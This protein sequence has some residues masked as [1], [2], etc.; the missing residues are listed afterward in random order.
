MADDKEKQP[1]SLHPQKEVKTK[2]AAPDYKKA[3]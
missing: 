1:N 3:D 2:P